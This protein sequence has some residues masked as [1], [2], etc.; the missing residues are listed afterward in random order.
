MRNLTRA[1]ILTLDQEI[2]GAAKAGGRIRTTLAKAKE[3][4]PFV[5]KLVTTAVKA[6]K[7]L[8]VANK[9]KSPHER[10]SDEHKKWRATEAGQAWLK[11]QGKYIQRRRQLF[12][13]LRSKKAVILLIEQVAPRFEDRP[14]GYTQ[15]GRASC[16]ERVYSSV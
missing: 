5:E 8:D 2:A 15:I 14:G 7:C 6:K 1:L 3:V 11:E 12:D 9:I 4:R 13:V 16:R 10:G